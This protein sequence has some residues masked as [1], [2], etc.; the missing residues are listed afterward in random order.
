MI[1]SKYWIT[2][3]LSVCMISVFG[4]FGRLKLKQLSQD[5]NLPGVTVRQLFQDSKGIMWIGVESYGLCRY[6]GYDF[7][8]FTHSPEDS[9][10][11]GNDVVEAMCEDGSGNI[12]AG[13]QQ[14]LSIYS[15]AEKK[16]KTLYCSETQ[17]RGIPGNTVLA[18]SYSPQTRSIWIGTSN[19]LA[20]FREQ[21]STIINIPI[22]T[23]N[24][25]I[26]NK[27]AISADGTIWSATNNGL[28]K[29]S[30]TGKVTK[31]YTVANSALASDNIHAVCT[32][33]DATLLVGCGMQ[34]LHF[35]PQTN[36]WS[37]VTYLKNPTEV[38]GDN[39]TDIAQD[40][41]GNI[42][43]STT[44][45][46][47]SILSPQLNEYNNFLPE[48]ETR[49]GLKSQGVRDIHVDQNGLVWLGLKFQGIQI[50]NYQSQLF[51][52]F[53]TERPAPG[54]LSNK[55]IISITE[56]NT[57]NI[58]FGT[59]KGGV[60]ILDTLTGKL[61][62]VTSA[63]YPEIQSA[64]INSLC[65]TSD[66]AVWIGTSEFL[67]RTDKQGRNIS[68]IF[69][70]NC[71]DITELN[72]EVW[73]GTTT[74]LRI[75]KNGKIIGL[76]EYSDKISDD[77]ILSIKCLYRDSRNNIWIGTL[78]SGLM[79]YDTKNKKLVAYLHECKTG[80]CLSGNH[81]R[82]IAEDRS[83]NI[84]ITTRG[85]GLN[86]YSYSDN[87]FTHFSERNGLPTNT[88]FGILIDNKGKLWISSYQGLCCF[89]PIKKTAQSF[90]KEYGLQNDI[91]EPKACCRASNGTFYFGGDNGYNFFHPE[92]IGSDK[93]SYPL[94]LTSVKLFDREIISDLDS[95]KTIILNYDENFLSF[96]FS[97][98]DYTGNLGKKYSYILEG[99][100]TQWQ[101]TLNR[102]YANY[103]NIEPGSYTLRIRAQSKDGAPC[104]NE[105]TMS[106]I[107]RPP[108]WKTLWFR[109]VFGLISAV[110]VYALITYR[111]FQERR[112]RKRL[113][114]LVNEKTEHLKR[115][116]QE[117]IKQNQLIE[118]TAAALEYKNSELQK[119]NTTKNT[120]IS[121]IAHDM[122]NQFA[123]IMGLSS[124]ITATASNSK[125]DKY[126]Q[127][128][129]N[130]TKAVND[131]LENLLHWYKSQH[132][133]LSPKIVAVNIMELAQ[134]IADNYSITA[135]NKQVELK[136]SMPND[137]EV[138]ADREMLSA[139]IRNLVN[140]AIKN[141]GKGGS[142]SISCE[143]ID[144]RYKL[145]VTDTGSG[146]HEDMVEMLFMPDSTADKTVNKGLGLQ[147]CKRF[148]D[149]MGSELTV[150]SKLGFGSSFSLSLQNTGSA[151]QG[152]VTQY[153]PQQ[154]T[155]PY[156]DNSERVENILRNKRILII[157]DNVNL[158]EHLK[159]I[160]SGFAKVSVAENGTD[161]L[162]C[163]E[164]QLPDLIVTDLMMPGINGIEL[165]EQLRRNPQTQ[166][167]PIILLSGQ[168]FESVHERAYAAG[169]TDFIAKPFDQQRFI[170]K[171]KNI[172]QLK[173]AIRY[174]AQVSAIDSETNG[175]RTFLELVIETIKAQ[176]DYSNFTVESLAEILC[177][178]KSTLI[179]KLKA[180]TD[181]APSELLNDI[182]FEKSRILL[183]SNKHSISE[184]AWMLG[185]NES[186]YF[187]KKFK[188]KYGK[189][190]RE[191]TKGSK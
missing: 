117:L 52:H 126:I 34:L 22:E 168:N 148:A 55:N 135:I 176:A 171:L 165:T 155:E 112:R 18:L 13:T 170:T 131:T 153:Y 177:M 1:K 154:V 58:W 180:E 160:L 78:N 29:V 28:L 80:K 174:K 42:W 50:F 11:I 19:G 41:R 161:G 158:L 44:T 182:R 14:G 102:H 152:I 130:A 144:G 27:I 60:N 107:I 61:R 51:P 10:S 110:T 15:R 191:Y 3:I 147:I 83:G 30:A 85:Q 167:I 4:Q 151:S 91:F 5:Q 139:I 73:I 106:I 16:F 53:N 122:K 137:A 81:I 121:V 33:A 49:D 129:S 76:A 172:F 25:L 143:L 103:T 48:S 128:I 86:K 179:R 189:S 71:I 57:G 178:S 84:W 108:F 66:E 134:I 163:A 140:N 105:I 62:Q 79:R 188:E 75:I 119:A 21:D 39:I 54:G 133:D 24:Q 6:D 26:V 116:T 111:L 145:S 9:T 164:S 12:W 17:K 2:V 181:K 64:R 95:S 94:I 187:S 101:H 132:T 142:V 92:K 186:K 157:D 36:A 69:P 43:I 90:T 115:Q 113:E 38:S 124:I 138:L 127:L 169:I 156:I 20:C 77:I 159:Q 118:D 93:Q 125:N 7:E 175:Q 104:Q 146:M 96:E 47:L 136:L 141:T 109:I 150:Y 46:G 8:L 31:Q 40:K 162:L 149:S 87:A 123:G 97:L 173:E 59:G 120:L 23:D 70:C 184:I 37:N 56:V 88:L 190:P 166:H 98:L 183:E 35:C 68:K 45:D 82:C 67:Y 74:G 100:D 114:F 65:Q 63:Q 99:F 89:D 72:G 185:F 32:L